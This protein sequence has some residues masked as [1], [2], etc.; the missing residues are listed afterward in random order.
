[1]KILFLAY[2]SQKYSGHN[3]H[4][5]RPDL[6]RKMSC[7]ETWV[8]RIEETGHE[9]IFFDGGYE[10]ISFDKKNKILHTNVSDSYDYH[11][12]KE[13]NKGS[14]MLER[15][16]VAVS[17]ALQNRAFD[18]IF[19]IDDG[20]YVNCYVLETMIRE[21]SGFDYVMGT[22]GG[23]GMF[24]SRKACE[25]LIQYKNET[26]IHIEDLS[27]YNF[28]YNDTDIKTKNSDLLTHQYILSEKLFSIHYTNGKRQYFVDNIISYYYNGHPIERKIV[29]NYE[30]DNFFLKPQ[31]CNTW[32]SDYETTPMYYS[33]DRDLY[34]WEHYGSFARTNFPVGLI[35]PFVKNTIK[36]LFF[37]EVVFDLSDIANGNN[38]FRKY[39][40]CL[41]D[42]ST[43]YFFYENN[44]LDEKVLDYLKLVKHSEKVDI[45]VEYLNDYKGNFYTLKKI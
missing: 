9:V 15:L 26:K 19:R 18:Y 37:Y 33:F 44:T 27:I 42:D 13:Q 8:P 1:M 4:I 29:L 14:L 24:F 12:L 38:V 28:V 7:L 30:K 39:I 16:K 35:C 34:N 41:K 6:T 2:T 40:E 25:K 45:R 31:K 17:W 11:Y 36:E 5:D 21:I 43:V 32:D 23:G 20:S 10:E 22:G 3:I